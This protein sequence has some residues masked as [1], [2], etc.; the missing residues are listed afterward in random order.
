[1]IYSLPSCRRHPLLHA[2]ENPDLVLLKKLIAVA[3]P[4]PEEAGMA[5]FVS[6]FFLEKGYEVMVQEVDGERSNVI[7]EKGRGDR[8]VV[9]YSHLDTVPAGTGWTREP[10]TATVEG[11][12]LYGRGAYDMKGG[13]AVNMNLF[14]ESEPRRFKLRALFAVDEENISRGGW[15]YAASRFMRD[16]DCVLSPEPGFAHGLQGIVTGRIGRAVIRIVLRSRPAHFYFYEPARDITIIASRVIAA[17]SRLYVARGERK[18]F[19]FVR[20][21]ASRS[22]GMSTPGEVEMELDAAVLPPHTNEDMLARVE[23]EVKKAVDGTGAEAHVFF[24]ERTTPFLSGYEAAPGNPYL[25]AMERAVG[26]VTGKKAVPYFRSSVAD[27][28]IFGA[29]GKTVLGIGPEGG[30]AHAPDE[31]V[32][33]SSLATLKEIYREFLRAQDSY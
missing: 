23:A 7:V 17:L 4:F 5:R 26:K 2:M 24:R 16:T 11:D 13:M 6:Q 25:A 30:Q 1:M 31:W 18:E 20:S 19:V 27:E 33:L 10:F 28:N 8:T 21:L 15:Q 22:S 29:A 32:S 12:R 3:S 9:L 14:L